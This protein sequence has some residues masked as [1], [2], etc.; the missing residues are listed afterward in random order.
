MINTIK[1]GTGAPETS[2]DRRSKRDDRNPSPLHEEEETVVRPPTPPQPDA[3][4]RLVIER[5]IEGADY[6]YRLV[7]RKTGKVVAELP[8]D[9]VNDLAQAPSYT[10]GSLVSTKA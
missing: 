3:D 9:K 6:I 2:T 5:D 10:A 1:A 8:R 4:F 7:D